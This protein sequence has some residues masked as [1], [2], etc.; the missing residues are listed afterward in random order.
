[1]ITCE[2]CKKEI[3]P[4][5]CLMVF[6]LRKQEVTKKM[7]GNILHYHCAGCNDGRVSFRCKKPMEFLAVV[8]EIGTGAIEA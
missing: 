1:M 5:E 8:C 3:R 4:M 6:G 2:K 7:E